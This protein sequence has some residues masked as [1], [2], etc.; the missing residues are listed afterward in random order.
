MLI[1]AF[2]FVRNGFEYDYPFIES[3]QS[4]L[5][6]CDEFIIAVGNSIDKTREAIININS[7]KIK[8][9]DTVWDKSLR[10]NGTILAQQT[11]IALNHATGKWAFYIQ[12][13]EVIHEKS[14]ETIRHFAQQYL[15]NKKVEGF[16]FN[17]HHFWGSYSYKAISRNWYRNEIRMFRNTGKVRSFRD[18]QGFRNYSSDH[19]YQSGETGK[20]LKVKKIDASIFHYGYARNPENMKKKSDDFHRWWHDDNWLTK[21]KNNDTN[22]N[23]DHYNILSEFTETHPAVMKNRIENQNWNFNYDNSKARISVKEKISLLAEN[24][25]GHRFGEYKNYKLLK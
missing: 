7:P 5:P 8:I 17:Y 14:I 15:S 1:S 19:E 22:F 18:A 25:T 11:N 16:L 9:I 10:K 20:K 23:Y 4:V 24:L 6:L 12:G 3:I 2:S 13:D 21:N